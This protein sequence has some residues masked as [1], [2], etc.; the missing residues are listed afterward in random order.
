MKLL[1]RQGLTPSS[2]RERTQMFDRSVLEFFMGLALDEARKGV[3][4]TSP[5]PAVGA[6]LVKNG[7]IL[8]RG[9]H[10][11]AGT[12]HA[13]VVALGQAKGKARGA[14][15]YTTLEPCDH[16]GRTPPCSVAILEAGIRRVVCG[17]ADPNPLVNG[18]GVGRLRKGGV[19]VIT[20]VLREEADALN[21]PFFKAV[22]RGLPYVTLK[23]AVTLDGKL[24]TGTG[25][26]R[27]V[28]SEQA[29]ERVHQLRDQADA[30]MVGANTVLRD[31]PL[32]TTRL[33]AGQG[34][35]AV[36][37]VVD[38]HLRIG[39]KAKIFNPRSSARCI[40]ATLESERSA[41]A[42]ALIK[43]GA[44]LWTVPAKA[45]RVD[46]KKLLQR[47]AKAGL[48]HVLVEG[49]AELFG[50]L[51]RDR[52]ADELW[53]FLAPKLVGATGLSW[54]GEL[55]IKRM[56]KALAVGAPKVEQVGPDLLLR[57]AL[58]ADAKR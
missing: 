30:I 36:R 51:L 56:A 22:Q 28:T 31:D 44:E 26:S 42:R 6:V 29:R 53:L 37:L 25:D 2:R 7:R 12:P 32:L 1:T 41:R 20:G 3:G 16:F 18:K 43:A 21:R 5:N 13:E 10:A 54:A 38:S 45:G 23:A 49:G 8:A 24:A 15:L 35:D 19:E 55:G 57:A 48:N 50:T 58:S 17:S 4:R 9:F 14:D 11:K 27:W 52:L 40:V 33:P 46:V 39:P 47:A 34:R